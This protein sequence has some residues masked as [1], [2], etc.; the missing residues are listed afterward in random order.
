MK[1][2]CASCLWSIVVQYKILFDVGCSCLFELN[3]VDSPQIQGL[4]IVTPCI[5]RAQ[6][7]SSTTSKHWKWFYCQLFLGILPGLMGNIQYIYIYFK[8]EISENASPFLFYVPVNRLSQIRCSVKVSF[9]ADWVIS[10]FHAT[11][12][13]YLTRF[14]LMKQDVSVL[15]FY[16]KFNWLVL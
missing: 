4:E 14:M 11:K 5:T 1:M 2:C 6:R 7:N 15:K 16:S 10:Y 13:K 12:M 9:A 3:T 8:G